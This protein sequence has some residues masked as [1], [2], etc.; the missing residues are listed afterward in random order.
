MSKK[1]TITQWQKQRHKEDDEARQREERK[2][3]VH[4]VVITSHFV[5]SY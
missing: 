2:I 5:E 4:E 1:E 3:N